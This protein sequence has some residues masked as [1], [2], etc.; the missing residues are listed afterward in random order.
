MSSVTP[1]LIK[2]SQMYAV[3]GLCVDV[4]TFCENK[5]AGM[6]NTRVKGEKIP[7]TMAVKSDRVKKSF[8]V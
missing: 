2:V 7:H 6:V 8:G 4:Y 5:T 3:N 1:H